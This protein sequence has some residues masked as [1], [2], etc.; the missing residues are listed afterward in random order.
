MKRRNANTINGIPKLN[1]QKVRTL[2]KK[3]RNKMDLD[4]KKNV[5]VNPTQKILT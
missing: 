2:M 3:N 4:M 5:H 1:M